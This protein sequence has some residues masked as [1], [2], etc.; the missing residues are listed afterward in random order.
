[1]TGYFPYHMG[2]QQGAIEKFQPKFMPG[3]IKTLP[4][5]LKDMGYV[6]H[7]VGK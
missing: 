7:M 2:M 6:T 5:G 3:D 1:M 4:E